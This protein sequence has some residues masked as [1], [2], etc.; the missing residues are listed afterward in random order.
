MGLM[1]E[2][3]SATS[4]PVRVTYR[5]SLTSLQPRV[6]RG[7]TVLPGDII[8]TAHAAQP[9]VM[10][11]VAAAL[12]KKR[13]SVGRNIALEEGTLIEHQQKIAA[14]SGPF[15]FG[16]R[17]VVSP[18]AGTV[19]AVMRE[20]ALVV[21]RPMDRTDD[22]RSNVSGT[23]TNATTEA[24]EI[25][26]SGFV[27]RGTVGTGGETFGI[28]HLIPPGSS[29]DG[30]DGIEAASRPAVLASRD[31][32]G[33]A[34]LDRVVAAWKD[35]GV[36]ALVVPSVSQRDFDR[37]RVAEQGFVLLA[38][39]G[40]AGSDSIA[41]IHDSI[42]S[43]LRR[44]SGRPVAVDAEFDL[45][46][47]RAPFVVIPAEGGHAM[48]GSGRSVALS[49]GVDVRGLVGTSLRTAQLLQVLPG[50]RPVE[51]GYVVAGAEVA[52]DDGSRAVIA[53]DGLEPVATRES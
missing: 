13:K 21:V 6:A 45:D 3:A 38:T 35:G 28:L 36:S 43:V 7:D 40:F 22:V 50:V 41:S 29:F 23:V 24:V 32:I 9:L 53:V 17:E 26:V 34:E 48:A 33:A 5:Y 12:N 14:S 1:Y 11:D 52:M 46:A 20:Q 10:I 2:G 37:V 31:P 51:S 47:A 18:V 44:S 16:K 25:E 15:G 42:W 30:P 4:Q 8:A 19:E 39:E 49:D 27:I